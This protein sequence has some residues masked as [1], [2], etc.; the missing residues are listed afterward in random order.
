MSLALSGKP[1]NAGGLEL[2]HSSVDFANLG[3]SLLGSCYLSNY[4][5]NYGSFNSFKLHYEIVLAQ[6]LIWNPTHW[7]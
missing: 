5:Q 2:L 4:Q 1:Q 7:H 3:L 6:N